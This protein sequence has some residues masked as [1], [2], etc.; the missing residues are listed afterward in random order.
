MRAHALVHVV[1]V[2]F[3][4]LHA[5]ASEPGQPLN[6]EDWIPMQPGLS[7]SDNT[8]GPFPDVYNSGVLSQTVEIDAAGRSIHLG[9]VNGIT[10]P[11]CPPGSD[12]YPTHAM[13]VA[14]TPQREPVLLACLPRRAG[15]R[16]DSYDWSEWG[17]R[18]CTITNSEGCMRSSPVTGELTFQFVAI[19]F[20]YPPGVG[21]YRAPVTCV[22][23]GLPTL[24]NVLESFEP[25]SQ[26][27]FYVPPLPEGLAG[28]D[29][30]DTYAGDIAT[31][32]DFTRA[33][34]LQC[35]YPASSPHVGDYPTVE[36]PL[37]NPPAGHGRYY[38]T[39]ATYQGQTRYG[40]KGLRGQLSGRDPSLLP[41]CV[42]PQP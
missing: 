23:H 28:V 5:F 26:L 6:C 8:N 3:V 2:L 36:D 4:A 29:H 30:F 31:L 1:A 20:G 18:Q 22:L 41:A 24:M 19:G 21:N 7:I 33:Q 27:G 9:S 13:I 14:V 37:P 11:V 12:G 32:G 42:Q 34:P 15:S 39:A 40:R 38:V 10:A 16:P 25:G 17:A 35:N